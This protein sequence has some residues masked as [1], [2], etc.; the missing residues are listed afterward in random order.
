MFIK[1]TNI[2]YSL[3]FALLIGQFLI[4]KTFAADTSDT[5]SI[6][7]HCDRSHIGVSTEQ[8][9]TVDQGQSV[10]ITSSPD[11]SCDTYVNNRSNIPAF[12]TLTPGTVPFSGSISF[13]IGNSAAAGDYSL[14]IYQ[15]KAGSSHPD[16]DWGERLKFT[17]LSPT[18]QYSISAC[19]FTPISNTVADGE[20]S[21]STITFNGNRDS[22]G[23]VTFWHERLLDGTEITSGTESE[24][25]QGDV[26]PI[27]GYTY[28]YGSARSKPY[29]YPGQT[30]VEN[31]YA[32]NRARTAP[33]GSPLCTLT[34]TFT[35]STTI[36]SI[37]PNSG[38]TAGG[39]S[40]VI[41]GTHFTG[42]SGTSAVRFGSQDATSYTVNSST[43]I[44][45][46]APAASEGLVDITVT[47]TYGTSA[48]S[49]SDQF[50]Y[51]APIDQDPIL[52][53]LSTNSGPVGT[54]TVTFTVIGGSGT[55]AKSF[56]LQNNI[57]DIDGT[58]PGECNLDD[59]T[60]PKSI[61]ANNL[62]NCRVRVTKAADST[63]NEQSS[64]WVR[65]YFKAQ[66]D[67]LVLNIE[68]NSGVLTTKEI[69]ATLTG[70]TTADVTTYSIDP[71]STATGCQ[72]NDP[73]TPTSISATTAG[74]CVIKVVMPGDATHLDVNTTFVFTFNGAVST[75]TP[76]RERAPVMT[77]TTT[78]TPTPQAPITM[79][80]IKPGEIKNSGYA[81]SINSPNQIVSGKPEISISLPGDAKVVKVIV[82]GKETLGQ[83]TPNSLQ[84]PAIVGPK[85]DVKV[86]INQSGQEVT[87]PVKYVPTDISLANV[88]FNSNSTALT[89]SA[90]KLIKLVAKSILEHGF[91][92]VDLSGH[93]DSQSGL[94][95]DNQKLSEDRAKAVARY[96][97]SLLKNTGVKVET[98]G[99]GTSELLSTSKTKEAHATNRRV[100]IVVR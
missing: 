90:K 61:T 55:G 33:Y 40:V 78:P 58:H 47:G 86:V 38:P 32:I 65:F 50:T 23:E 31:I 2:T 67:P 49:S 11:G 74:T 17:V 44:T 20:S 81:K 52:L 96:L 15:K 7:I 26:L 4:P 77:P 13:T 21:Q 51:V 10:S 35:L 28:T 60:N 88:N 99:K 73:T 29:Y 41:T 59:S 84:L 62:G 46:I 18:Y 82:N 94:N 36:T 22:N 48:T 16:D 24:V 91:S 69:K 12:P 76:S 83:T 71:S 6:I 5:S 1:R 57:D 100:E 37:S 68:P 63:Y 56:T 97:Q 8:S 66:Q 25:S 34:T 70:G 54:N 53:E 95:I 89:P 85:D 45:A 30:L 93:A 14:T 42:L 79:P 72:L 39:T 98:I 64:N 9:F 80:S 3:I 43:Q 75:P 19:T 92:S 27:G 87:V